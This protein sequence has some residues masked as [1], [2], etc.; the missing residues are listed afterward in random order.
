M[1]SMV[2][3]ASSQRAAPLLTPMPAHRVEAF[4]RVVAA[5]LRL[6]TEANLDPKAMVKTLVD[7]QQ[8]LTN[9]L[10]DPVF[11]AAMTQAFV[12]EMKGQ[13][14]ADMALAEVHGI[15]KNRIRDARGFIKL[16]I[17]PEFMAAALTESAQPTPAAKE[18]DLPAVKKEEIIRRLVQSNDPDGAEPPVHVA[19]S[20]L[21]HSIVHMALA[22]IY[23]PKAG[24]LR[25]PLAQALARAWP[26]ATPQQRE[27]LATSWLKARHDP[28]HSIGDGLKEGGELYVEAMR[29]AGVTMPAPA[30]TVSVPAATLATVKTNPDLVM[31]G[32]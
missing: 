27:Q 19:A 25:E 5:R 10:A 20:A 2:S 4:R 28:A 16:L 21:G 7:E 18:Y 23:R 32:I 17:S 8:A 15:L 26:E 11:E 3:A 1:V 12:T 22:N 30:V 31:D 29:R 24:N 9:A 13:I 14:S 6:S